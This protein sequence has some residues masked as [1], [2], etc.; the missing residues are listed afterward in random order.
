MSCKFSQKIGLSGNSSLKFYR[1]SFPIASI[2]L[3]KD[4]RTSLCNS[5][6]IRVICDNL[7][8]ISAHAVFLDGVELGNVTK[9]F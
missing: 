4:V 3:N 5:P 7:A 6:L 8:A 9:N 1:P 2:S